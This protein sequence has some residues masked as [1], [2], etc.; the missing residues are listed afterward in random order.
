MERASPSSSSI[1]SPSSGSTSVSR[2][3][4]V[5]PQAGA[6]GDFIRV[7][8]QPGEPVYQRRIDRLR[9]LAK[10]WT[11]NKRWTQVMALVVLFDAYCN[12]ADIDARAVELDAPMF[13]RVGA[14]VCLI[15]PRGFY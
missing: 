10:Q 3:R 7:E 15:L 14:T 1:D 4:S 9:F 12:C 13:V 2:K 5:A 11:S 8:N 6:F